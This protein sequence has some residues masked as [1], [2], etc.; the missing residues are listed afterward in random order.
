MQRIIL[1]ILVTLL[2]FSFGIVFSCSTCNPSAGGGDDDYDGYDGD[3]ND[4][5]AADDD[6]DNTDDWDCGDAYNYLYTVCE[7]GFYQE[8]NQLIPVE[9]IIAYCEAGLIIFS[10]VF[11]NCIIDNYSCD[12]I[13]DCLNPYPWGDDD[14]AAAPKIPHDDM[15]LP[16][17]DCHGDAHEGQYDS[18]QCLICHSYY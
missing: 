4:D 9:D 11:F 12:V 5:T 1:L 8:D 16:C 2:A 3:D 14:S 13:E 7:L 17:T 6:S 10:D 18:N 15:G